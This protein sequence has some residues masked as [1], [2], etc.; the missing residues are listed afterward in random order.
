MKCQ[1]ILVINKFLNIAEP[2]MNLGEFIIQKLIDL[3]V[4]ITVATS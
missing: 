3:I 2:E 1:F 4:S